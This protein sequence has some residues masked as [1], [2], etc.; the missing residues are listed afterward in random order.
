[1]IFLIRTLVLASFLA[2]FSLPT[3]ANLFLMPG[4]VIEGH[5]KEEEDCDLCHKKFDKEAQPK[6][7]ADCHK[8]IRKDLNDKTGYHGR[9]EE[10][11]QCNECHTEH[12]GR[13]AKIVIF[14]P[15]KFD[16]KQTDYQLIDKHADSKVECEDCH[17]TGKK[18]SEASSICYDCHKKDDDEDGHKGNY[19]K[20]CETCHV[21]KGWEEIEFDHDKETDYKLLHKHIE[22]ECDSC[23]KGDL[24]EDKIEETTCVSCHKKD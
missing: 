23:H 2:M 16:H 6:L 13:D 15:D 20:K 24:Y 7:C 19:G 21:E 1:M 18:Y 11:K 14:D 10:D 8:D 4:D 22:A 9:I 3:Q 12:K 5:V 17:K